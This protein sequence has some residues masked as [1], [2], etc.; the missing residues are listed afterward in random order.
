MLGALPERT[1]PM[2]TIG[3]LGQ[4]APSFDRHLEQADAVA[5]RV[6]DDAFGTAETGC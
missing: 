1:I 5:S 6:A 3:D 4:L 2:D